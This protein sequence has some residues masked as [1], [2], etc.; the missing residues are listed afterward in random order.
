M[1]G[2]ARLMFIN[3]QLDAGREEA[4]RERLAH[5]ARPAHPAGP[6]T[7]ASLR[8]RPTVRTR[9]AALVRRTGRRPAAA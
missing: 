4:S 2:M 5:T 6:A 3:L 9:L 8:G 7:A 1:D